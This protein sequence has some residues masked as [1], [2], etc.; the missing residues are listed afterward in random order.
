MSITTTDEL[1]AKM[2][3]VTYPVYRADVTILNYT[4]Y[5]IMVENRHGERQKLQP[6]RVGFTGQARELQVYRRFGNRPT[7]KTDDTEYELPTKLLRIP[8]N[9]INSGHGLYEP[10]TDLFFTTPDCAEHHPHLHKNEQEIYADAVQTMLRSLQQQG[11]TMQL[12][13][14]DPKKA[15][16]DA[17]VAYVPYLADTAQGSKESYYSISILHLPSRQ[18]QPELVVCLS[19]NQQRQELHYSLA[20]LREGHPQPLP[21]RLV[22]VV[23]LTT[24]DA[25]NWNKL[26][27]TFTSDE[28]EDRV[29]EATQE[30]QA[31][32]ADLEQRCDELR[33]STEILK[34]QL[35]RVSQEKELA[36]KSEPITLARERAELERDRYR[37]E[38]EN[39]RFMLQLQRE[40]MDH[41]A[42]QQKMEV[43]EKE[44]KYTWFKIGATLL[45]SAAGLYLGKKAKLF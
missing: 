4:G 30:L 39:K 34:T 27:R 26:T 44:N 1:D 32:K 20:Q 9:D 38:L 37:Y 19:Q 18:T 23:A 36:V 2:P 41:R 35:S 10:L 42:S 21:N 25:L 45:V 33:K 28:V 3:N 5:D 7:I 40:Y 24:D 11:T 29:Q 12:H 8:L 43:A 14:N 13:I 17:L 16:G 15:L 22:P 6:L 31:S